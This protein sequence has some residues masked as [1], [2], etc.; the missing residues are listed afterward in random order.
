MT[1]TILMMIVVVVLLWEM[2][3]VIPVRTNSNSK[4]AFIHFRHVGVEFHH[5]AVSHHKTPG[6]DSVVSWHFFFDFS[7]SPTSQVVFF[8]FS[9]EKKGKFL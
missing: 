2:T 9:D 1:T 3:I 8:I 4:M 5:L 6:T 7:A